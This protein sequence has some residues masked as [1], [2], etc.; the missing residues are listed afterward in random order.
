V[1]VPGAPNGANYNGSSDGSTTECFV[2]TAIPTTTVTTPSDSTG[3]ALSSPVALGTTLYDLAVV[4]ANTNGDGPVTGTVDFF[5]CDPTQVQ[6]LAGAENCATGGTALSGNPRT[7]VAV[8]PATTP[9]S[10][11]VLSSPG[12]VAH[13]AGV[14]CFRAVYTPPT[15]SNYTGSSDASHRECV[16][17]S[18]EDTSTVTTPRATGTTTTFTTGPV[19]SWV[20]DHAIVSAIDDADGYPS[21]TI[22]FFIC[23]PTTVT[24][25]GGDCHTGGVAAGSKTAAELTGQTHPSSEATSDAVTATSVGTWCF[26][27]VYVPG[28]I[29]GANYN[30]SSDGSTTECFLITDSTSGSSAQTWVPNDSGTVAATGGTALNGTLSIQLYEGTGCVAGSEVSGQLYSKTL[31]NAS[32][33]ASRTLVTTNS[34]YS[35]SVTKS[36][37]WKVVFTPTAGSNVSGSSHCENSSLTITN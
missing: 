15:G 12:I 9:P 13:N 24:S 18:P 17:V 27:A 34:T 35:V 8:S 19:G 23:N 1:Y 2:I 26:R 5:L 32:T 21:G 11:K 29:N 22:N 6:G 3:T 31:T 25:N 4:S 14:Y 20:S 30:G 16:T 7:L 10:A 36:V 33:A 37:S 28:G